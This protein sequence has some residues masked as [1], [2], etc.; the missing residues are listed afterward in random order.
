MLR[1]VIAHVRADGRQRTVHCPAHDDRHPSL[2]VGRGR[3]GRILL[4]CHAGC[5]YEAIVDA[6]GIDPQELGPPRER[7]PERQPN[8]PEFSP[9]ITREAVERRRLELE[10]EPHRLAWARIER[11]I[12]Q[13]DGTP[14]DRA[15][16]VADVRSALRTVRDHDVRAAL[17]REAEKF[18]QEHGVR[19][20]ASEVLRVLAAEERAANGDD[21]E[22]RRRRRE[23]PQGQAVV[24][25]DPEPWPEPVDGAELL[26]ELAATFSRF[27]ALPSDAEPETAALWVVHAHAH[28]AAEASALLAVTSPAPRCGKTRFLTLLGALVPRPLP[29]SDI[30]PAAL[31]RTIERERPTLLVDEADD[32]GDEECARE[33]R[34]ILRAGYTHMTAYIV[35]CE[36]DNHEPRTF[37][38]W[39]P[40]AVALVGR[41][42]GAL[43]DRAIEIR[44]RRRRR[45]EPIARLR[46]SRIAKELEPLRRRCARWARDHAD[47]LR[48][49]DVAIPP[50][51]D[52]RA[53]E[54]W[55][56]LLAIADQAGGTWPQ[57]ARRAALALSAGMVRTD[58][59]DAG[60][61]LLADLRDLYTD[62]G[63]AE[64][65]TTAEILEYLHTAP[66][67]P[68]AAWHHG[69]PLSDQGLARLLRPYGVH[70]RNLRTG[71]LVRKGYR[72]DDLVDAWDR[73]LGASLRYTAT[74]QAPQALPADSSPLQDRGCSGAE[75]G[76]KAAPRLGCSG[77][78]EMRRQSGGGE[79]SGLEREDEAPPPEPAPRAGEEP[80]ARGPAPGR[81]RGRI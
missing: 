49:A 79:H 32:I 34:R 21:A 15:A 80:P 71:A 63:G 7:R 35:R 1:D 52:D 75:I 16:A 6:A 67:R 59:D 60:T 42:R 51:L 58:D 11:A 41:L 48:A 3:D 53:A 44:M 27:L 74:F 20:R 5:S 77:V 76:R 39:C 47:A 31:Y 17:A 73:Y 70:S 72:R 28:D 10:F 18:A 78:A 57:R 33:L 55:G 29:T 54:L 9:Q 40:K 81:V 56:P 24:L 23:K 19:L 38:V 65:L 26:T 14:A 22:P 36:G 64:E 50:E 62:R 25:S 66:E 45:D 30:S 69:R 61:L 13:T 68:W 12:L 37:S 4:K 46:A 8:R 43:G 2:S